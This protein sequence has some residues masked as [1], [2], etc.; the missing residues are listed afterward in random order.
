LDRLIF[1]GRQLLK[2]KF[3]NIIFMNKNIEI[4]KENNIISNYLNMPTIRT[5]LN[6][7]NELERVL[8]P[9]ERTISL[10]HCLQNNYIIQKGN[11]Y[12]ITSTGLNAL[13]VIVKYKKSR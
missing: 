13:K 8:N 1:L 5:V 9:F 6:D 4:N 2:E 11:K 7:V 12:K 10:R 3:L